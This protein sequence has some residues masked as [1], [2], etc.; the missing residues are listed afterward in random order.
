MT[1]PCSLSGKVEQAATLEL[2]CTAHPLHHQQLRHCK[3]LCKRWVK[4]RLVQL[5]AEQD[6][7]TAQPTRMLSARDFR[8]GRC[9]L[10]QSLPWP[11][12]QHTTTSMVPVAG[13]VLHPFIHSPDTLPSSELRDMGMLNSA[14]K[15]PVFST[16]FVCNPENSLWTAEE[17]HMYM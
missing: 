10:H 17:Q 6:R 4:S 9:L 14:H 2:P 1:A 11:K 13:R 7:F 3:R 15:L 16:Q 5:E 8:T 12:S